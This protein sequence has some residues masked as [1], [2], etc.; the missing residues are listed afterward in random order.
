MGRVEYLV[1]TEANLS[2]AYLLGDQT[3]SMGISCG[4]GG[5]GGL[6]GTLMGLMTGA[7]MCQLWDEADGAGGSGAGGAIVGGGGGGGGGTDFGCF[8]GR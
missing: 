2:D 3:C 6:V 4:G 8:A 7:A 1:P 5:G